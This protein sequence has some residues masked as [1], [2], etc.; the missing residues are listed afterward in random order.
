M[1]DVSRN[2]CIGGERSLI[3]ASGGS[4]VPVEFDEAGNG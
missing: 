2:E 3:D 4:S 1:R